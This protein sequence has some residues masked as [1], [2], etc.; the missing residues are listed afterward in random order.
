MGFNRGSAP[1]RY[2]VAVVFVAL[3]V[4]I[5]LLLDPVLGMAFPFATVFFAILMAAWF[6]GFWPAMLAVLAGALASD[7]FLLPP[8]GSFQLA[9]TEEGLGL[10]LFVF[11]GAGIAALGGAMDGA[12]RRAEIGARE[13]AGK[14]LLVDQTHDAII[15]WGW[16]G[17]ITFWNRGAERKYGFTSE[18]ALGRNCHELLRTESTIGMQEVTALLDRNG[19]WEGELEHTGADGCKITVESKMMLVRDKAGAS[20]VETNRDITKRRL[21]E[22]ALREA[23][24]TLEARVAERTAELERS[25]AHYRKLFDYAPDGVI[26]S[27]G[28]RRHVDVNSSMCRMLGYTREEIIAM[29]AAE[30]VAA[31]EIVHIDPTLEAIKSGADYLRE[32]QFRR[33][34]GSTFPA[35]VRATSMPGGNLLVVIHDV[36][37]RRAAERALSEKEALLRTTDRRLAEIV[38]GMKEACFALDKE[39]RF[40]FVNENVPKLLKHSPEEMLGRSIWEVFHKLAGT[41]ME[42]YYR[43]A[44]KERVAMQFEVY[45]PIAERWV[46][47]RLFPTP[48]G[49]AAFLLDIQA[50]KEAETVIRESEERFRAYVE[51]AA[52]AL[53]VHDEMGRFL[54]VN[55]QA[56]LSLGYTREE[57]LRMSVPDLEIDFDL[58]KAQAAWAQIAPDEAFTLLGHQRRKDGSVFP[59]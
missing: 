56:C 16:D 40:T 11:T 17:R 10:V 2:G 20:V 3:A 22:E 45:S 47:V 6:G 5:R 32:W 14:A 26:I 44:M 8:R 31:D 35:E 55:R 23:N 24:E 43:R 19:S 46:D 1:A 7:Y 13:S 52:D 36:T 38:H 21:A 54:E 29:E 30:I 12:R 33:K 27:D 25:E 57:L 4:W 49:L 34:D 39:C 28:N 37:A 59:V 42:G 18:Q 9:S 15:V 51:Q 58:P 53:F 48:E 41:P 50:R